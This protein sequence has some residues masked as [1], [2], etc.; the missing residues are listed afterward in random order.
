MYNLQDMGLRDIIVC[1]SFIG[2]KAH[3]MGEYLS[4]QQCVARAQG[5]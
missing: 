5:H 2:L 1:L 3:V 4:V